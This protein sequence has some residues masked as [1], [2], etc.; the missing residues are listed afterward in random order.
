[1][2]TLADIAREAVCSIKTVSRAVNNSAEI[3]PETAKRILEIARRLGYSPHGPARSLVT[4][5]T[6]VVGVVMPDAETP[7]Y[8]VLVNEVERAFSNMGYTVLLAATHWDVSREESALNLFRAHKV[9]GIIIRPVEVSAEHLQ[10]VRDTNIPMVLVFRDYHEL[11]LDYVG[12]NALAGASGA[13]NHLLQLGHRHIGYLGRIPRL[14]SVRARFEGY[15]QA[16][17]EHDVAEDERLVHIGMD[18]DNDLAGAYRLTLELLDQS[19]ECTAIF[20]DSGLAAPGITRALKQVGRRVPDDIALVGFGDSAFAAYLDPPLT[21]VSTPVAQEGRLAADLLLRRI[22]GD[23][24]GYPEKIVV[25]PELIV[26]ESCGAG[27]CAKEAGVQGSGQGRS[28]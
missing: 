14:E 27:V 26:R 3:T 6:G 12:T 1:M 7:A 25:P 11:Q 21:C 16:L 4:G 20:T 28:D 19:P 8:S 13:V 9:E 10:A 17:R 22:A 2:A 18:G 5:R 15:R 24:A 23:R